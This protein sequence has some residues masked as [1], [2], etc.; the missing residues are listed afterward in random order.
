MQKYITF[1][2]YYT[3]TEYNNFLQNIKDSGIPYK[4]YVLIKPPYYFYFSIDEKYI[5]IFLKYK[6]LTKGNERYLLERVKTLYP[7]EDFYLLRK[8]SDSTLNFEKFISPN[9]FKQIATEQYACVFRY[10]NKEQLMSISRELGIQVWVLGRQRDWNLAFSFNKF[11]KN[12]IPLD[13]VLVEKTKP[14]QF[15][16]PG[17]FEAYLNYFVLHKVKLTNKVIN[18]PYFDSGVYYP[19]KTT[20]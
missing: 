10:R 20:S 8:E 1:D 16:K 7:S 3:H 14:S 5:P 6:E 2:P 17:D 4:E 9:I 18:Y 11:I 13:W 19:M 15:E 12:Y